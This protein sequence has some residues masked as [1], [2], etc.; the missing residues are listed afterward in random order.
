LLGRAQRSSA[1]IAEPARTVAAFH[2]PFDKALLIAPRSLRR[3]ALRSVSEMKLSFAVVA[4]G[5][6]SGHLERP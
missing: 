5:F 4:E 2:S 3:F 1:S 6:S